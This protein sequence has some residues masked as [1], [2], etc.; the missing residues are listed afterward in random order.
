MLSISA[1]L[2]THLPSGFKIPGLTDKE[3][4]AF[5]GLAAW[6]P[7]EGFQ[8]SEILHFFGLPENDFNTLALDLVL[9]EP[10]IWSR[11]EATVKQYGYHDGSVCRKSSSNEEMEA[12]S[13]VSP[14]EPPSNL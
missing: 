4:Q 13:R 8:T 1:S 9:K 6:L 5:R 3:K 12:C 14:S 10:P 7:Q 11:C 2:W